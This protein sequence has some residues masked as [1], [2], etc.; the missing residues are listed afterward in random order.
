MKNKKGYVTIVVLILMMVLISASYLYADAVY[1]E[2]GIARNNKGASIAFSLAEGGIQEAINRI[3]YD[4]VAT[5]SFLHTTNGLISFSHDPALI[6]NGAYSV[7]IQNT[8][9]GVA[10]INAVGSY[11][12]GLKTARREIQASIARATDLTYT[13]DGAMYTTSAGG[14]STGDI[15]LTSATVIVYDGAI[16]SGRDSKVSQT[17]LTIEKSFKVERNL[18]TPGSTLNC[19]CL[20]EDDGDPLTAQCSD[21][22]GCSFTPT[23]G[24]EMPMID[25]DSDSSG[26]Y[27]SLA[28][29]LNQYYETD[30]D[31]F[32]ATGFTAGTTK[33]LDGVVYIDGPL[34][35]ED[36][37]TLIMNGVLAASGTIKVGKTSGGTASQGTITITSPGDNQPSGVISQHDIVIN[38]KGNL[39]GKGLIYSGTKVDIGASNTNVELEGGILSRRIVVNSR[40]IVIH[41]NADVINWTLDSPNTTPV[42][43]INH[44]EEEY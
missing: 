27:K 17:N 30:N 22:P 31:F 19:N 33:T 7:T 6:N 42:I 12:M 8:G 9:L 10:S 35:L 29:S 32:T 1:S 28:E 39:A 20:I 25:F 16:T 37:R 44:W 26:S 40:T 21:N 4:P 11:R 43:E 14:E 2:M 13:D 18:T 41:F 38:N 5:N 24:G 34:T 36:N 15:E 23:S 3:Q